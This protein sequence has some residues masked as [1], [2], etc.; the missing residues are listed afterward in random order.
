VKVVRF[1]SKKEILLFLN[2]FRMRNRMR[3]RMIIGML[4]FFFAFSY[5]SFAQDIHFSQFDQAILWQNSAQVGAFNGQFRFAANQ[6]NQWR[7]VTTPYQT[8]G[9]SAEAKEFNAKPWSFGLNAGSDVAGDSRFR[10]SQVQLH[11]AHTLYKPNDSLEV[12][13]G[14]SFGITSRGFDLSALIYDSQWNG[15]SFDPTLSTNEVYAMT[16]RVYPSIAMSVFMQKQQEQF[17]WNLGYSLNNITRPKQS[18]KDN[19]AIVLD[20]RHSIQ[21]SARIPLNNQYEVE[22]L[23]LFQR[24]GKMKELVLGSRVFYKL[25][26]EKWEN[27]RVFAGAHGRFRDAAWIEVGAEYNEWRV[28]MSY[29]LNTSTLRP[30]STGRGGL[31]F[32]IVYIVPPKPKHGNLKK[33]CIPY[34]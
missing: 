19:N 13:G 10:T 12:R 27:Q 2:N 29:D 28:G 34:Y 8:F 23:T 1:I 9:F 6:R 3:N 21:A 22:A 14:G 18:F 11:A 16:A 17:R 4:A 31:E 33:I 25:P 5:N 7:S 30:A 24:Q 20:M 26:S 15:M 32:S